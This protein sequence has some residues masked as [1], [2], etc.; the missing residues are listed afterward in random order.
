MTGTPDFAARDE[1][2]E[3]V[4]LR[5]REALGDNYNEELITGRFITHNKVV[6][7]AI[8][9]YDADQEVLRPMWE[10][11]GSIVAEYPAGIQ[12]RW[13]LHREQGAGG[14]VIAAQNEQLNPVLKAIQEEITKKRIIHKI[15]NSDADEAAIRLGYSETPRTPEGEAE[16]S[17]LRIKYRQD[18]D[19]TQVIPDTPAITPP[20]REELPV[21][22]R[23]PI[24]QGL[25]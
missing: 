2:R 6:D 3:N 13:R 21:V 20:V 22:E 15:F 14:K 19:A 25:R 9:Q 11:E 12:R 10:I 17:R 7:E 1:V 5:A 23:P 18:F 4:L 8:A 16:L 24:E